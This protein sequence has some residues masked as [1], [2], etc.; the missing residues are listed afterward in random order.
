MP[1]RLLITGDIH[2]TTHPADE[3]RWEIF[4]WLLEQADKRGVGAI[5]ILGDLT[6]KKDAH[7]ARLVNRAHAALTRSPVPVWV[8]MGNHD[9]DQDPDCPFFG[10][11]ANFI[12]K[13]TLV[14]IGDLRCYF[15][16]HVRGMTPESVPSVPKCEFL[17]MHQTFQGAKAE[18]GQR[19]EGLDPAEFDG[20]AKVATVSGDIH[21]PQEIGG[22]VYAGAPHPV[23]FG[24]SFKPRVL[25]WDGKDLISVRRPTI[26]K[27]MLEIESLDD[28]VEAGLRSGDQVKVRYRM[29]RRDFPERQQRLEEVRVFCEHEGIHLH[30]IRV[31]ALETERVRIKG[32]PAP[33]EA[34][35]HLEIYDAFCAARRID[36]A[37]EKAGRE[38]LSA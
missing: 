26:R 7:P 9:Y 3:Y 35:S 38:F 21:V 8:M 28:L 5:V 29:H 25:Y 22:I 13:P 32:E 19:L 4:P 34:R 11:L 12:R 30:G 1:T 2:L 27:A 17:F 36:P 10:F 18:N 37:Y 24:D 16:P 20:L 33:K 31:E 23:R 14:T 15:I 6:D